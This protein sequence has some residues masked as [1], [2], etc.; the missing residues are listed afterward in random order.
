[1]S[2]I[3]PLTVVRMF[4]TREDRMGLVQAF[5]GRAA[6]LANRW[7]REFSGAAKAGSRIHKEATYQVRKTAGNSLSLFPA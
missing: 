3:D 5:F 2:V 7:N 1:M 6:D 4:G